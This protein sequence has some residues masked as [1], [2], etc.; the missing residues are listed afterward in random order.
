MQ[1]L[2]KLGYYNEYD[3]LEFFQF[4]PKILSSWPKFELEIQTFQK[5]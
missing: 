2:S 3:F 5:K 4:F 1:K